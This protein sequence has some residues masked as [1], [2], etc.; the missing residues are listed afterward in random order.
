MKIVN[1]KKEMEDNLLACQQF[2][3]KSHLVTCLAKERA[4]FLKI[5]DINEIFLERLTATIVVL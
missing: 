1:A 4:S 5:N 3:K 2:L